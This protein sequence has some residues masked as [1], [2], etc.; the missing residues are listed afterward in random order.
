MTRRLASRS[1]VRRRPAPCG[2]WHCRS[3]RRLAPLLVALLM[4]PP[5]M[6]T[7][8]PTAGGDVVVADFTAGDAGW[9]GNDQIVGRRR[10]GDG[11]VLETRG[12]DPYLIGPPIEVPVAAPRL[13]IRLDADPL[14][15]GTFR[16]YYAPAK[17]PFAES[18]AVTLMVD[19][20]DPSVASAVIT[21]PA[22]V[23]RF[24]I[25]PPGGVTPVRLR[26]LSL[27]AVA[28]I[29]VPLPRRPAKLTLPAHVERVVTGSLEAI[30]DPATWNALVIEV[31]GLRFAQTV[32]DDRIAW[33]D[34]DAC[35]LV[36]PLAVE[37]ARDGG[38]LRVVAMHRD[39]GADAATWRMTRV[40]RAVDGALEI[41][42]TVAVDRPRDVVHLPWLTLVAGLGSFGAQKAGALLPGVEYLDDEPSGSEA[43]IRGADANR[44]IVDHRK[45]CTPLTAVAAG[46]RWLAIDWRRPTG[47]DELAAAPVFDSP[48]RILGSDGHLLGLWSPAVGPCRE[49]GA[50]AVDRPRRL[51]PERVY[52]HVVRVRGDRGDDVAAALADRVARDGLPPLPALPPDAVATDLEKASRLLAHGWLDS[53][54]RDGLRWRHAVWE[55]AFP[56]QPAA[57]APAAML[58]LAEHAGD[59]IVAARLRA[60]AAAAIA[61]FPPGASP[62][63]GIGHA[64]RPVAA[65]LHGD[66]AAAIRSAGPAA[67]EAARRLVEQ[68]GRARYT[69]GRF[70][71]AETLGADH[72]NGLT[73]IAVE[74]LLEQAS[75]SG[76]EEVIAAALAALERLDAD[77]P[78]G[79]P[80]GAQPWEMPLHT[81][82]ILAAARLVRCCT[83]G[84]L[85]SG[86]ARW[87]ARA[88][89]WAW[90]GATM[91]YLDSP[92]RGVPGAYATTGVIGATHW[93]A[94]N[95]IGQPVQWCGLVYAAALD[96]LARLATPH[97][98]TWRTIAAGI[99][100][101]GLQMTFPTDD[102]LRRGG[103]LPDY[104]LF[105]AARGDGPAI[106]PG[107]LQTSLPV[108]FAA[109][110]LCTATRLAA[111]PAA[112]GLVHVAG[113]VVAQA[114]E[115][116]TTVLDLDTWPAD[117]CHVV[118][119]RCALPRAIL[120]NG[121][122]VAATVV[123]DA[124]CIVVPVRGDGRLSI[125]W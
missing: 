12:D 49:Q 73:A 109:T 17:G 7:A 50:L 107:T 83:L 99:A 63:E 108:A 65:L 6:A 40:I 98:A 81:P 117:G 55:G 125:A 102:P 16:V 14:P 123:G 58:W 75:L 21:N 13:R 10:D 88:E 124:R 82:D 116:G 52:R 28:P 29:A 48:D 118:V 97:A 47:A 114:S 76:D 68:G 61:E 111:G 92:T 18:R 54:S 119:T 24:R 9:T 41:V 37:S 86:D 87:S 100:R 25:D 115:A 3:P 57:D 22:A 59:G 105:A 85:L 38:A 89:E 112:G 106:N 56:P 122:P 27:E 90:R 121:A 74:A 71:L 60:T 32:V 8:G 95:W 93:V 62:W 30:V 79:V 67:R 96:D 5:A 77:H 69:P 101:C 31:A 44:R 113:A 2:S 26:R 35:R 64:R 51:D 11:L 46:G 19:P 23:T 120:W 15:Q 33:W 39:A 104:W 34:G 66:A 70:D 36:D 72:C 53:A 91:V 103:L 84:H 94:P 45:V 78:R 20:D 80:R 43:E 110:P 42:T 1:A 4:L